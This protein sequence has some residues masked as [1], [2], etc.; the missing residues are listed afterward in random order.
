MD[1]AESEI[2]SRIRRCVVAG[3]WC[4]DLL[5]R[6]PYEAAYAAHL[7]VIGFAFDGQ[8]GVHAFGSDRRTDFQAMANGLAYVP[9]GCDVYSQSTHGG[10]YLTI[11]LACSHGESWPFSRR[12]SDV[13]D[14]L[15]ID[16]ARQLRRQLL[17]PH[18]VDELQCERFVQTL[19][20]RTRRVLSGVSTEPAARCWMTPRRLRLV[21]ELIEARL[22]AKVTVQDLADALG[23]SAGFFCRAF[24]AAV[25]QPPHDHIVDRRVSRAR[26][27]LRNPALD[28]SA[29][30]HA[31]G[32]ASHSHMTATFR[33]R[34]GVTPSELRGSFGTKRR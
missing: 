9:A 31:S 13:I 11:T 15:A 14:P 22:D 18:G 23:L 17:A 27:L 2:A 5:P 26:M 20:E 10:E 12:F 28:L 34:L 30:A 7:P 16:A 25:G 19:R 6:K 4:A 33:K 1:E 24:S 8:T 32:F 3:A 21:D 29:I